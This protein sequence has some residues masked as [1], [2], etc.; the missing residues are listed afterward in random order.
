MISAARPT[1]LPVPAVVGIAMTPSDES[2]PGFVA[3]DVTFYF[4][5]RDENQRILLTREDDRLVITS[6]SDS[7]MSTP[8]V[9][10]GTPVFEK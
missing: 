3:V 6:I 1:S 10:Y 5:D 9:P 8:A 2:L 4:V 7:M